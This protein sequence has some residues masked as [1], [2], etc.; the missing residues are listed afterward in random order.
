MFS[1]TSTRGQNGQIAHGI[2]D[3]EA[4]EKWIFCCSFSVLKG[5]PLLAGCVHLN[6]AAETGR[7]LR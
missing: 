2:F 1:S 3:L 4:G 6:G 5:L 7:L